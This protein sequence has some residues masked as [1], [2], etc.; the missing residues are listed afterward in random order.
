MASSVV[1][2]DRVL[3]S[4]DATGPVHLPAELPEVSGLMPSGQLPIKPSLALPP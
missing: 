3:K 1:K 4:L 2:G